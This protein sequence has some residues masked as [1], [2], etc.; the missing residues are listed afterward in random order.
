MLLIPHGEQDT[1]RQEEQI[2]GQEGHAVGTHILLC[3]TQRLAGQVFLHHVLIDARHHQYD[4]DAAEELFP[5]VLLRRPVVPD[6]D[7]RQLVA[8]D[9]AHHRLHAQSQVGG[10]LIYNKE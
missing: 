9:G 7:A 6:E 4:E 5:E 8:I 2:G 1:Q 3:P 10:Y